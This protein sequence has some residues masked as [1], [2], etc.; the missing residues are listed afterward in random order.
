MS[1]SNGHTLQTFPGILYSSAFCN[2]LRDSNMRIGRICVYTCG[3]IIKYF[4]V[5]TQ[6][7]ILMRTW[8]VEQNFGLTLGLYFRIR[9]SPWPYI[10]IMY[11]LITLNFVTVRVSFGVNHSCINTLCWLFLLQVNGDNGFTATVSITWTNKRPKCILLWKYTKQQC[12]C[13]IHAEAIFTVSVWWSICTPILKF[14]ASNI[15]EIWREFQNWKSR[16]LPNFAFF[17]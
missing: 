4:R 14:P 6:N 7:C 16:S 10:K 17:R 13:L 9:T 8:L 15:L 5:L 12:F 1:C 11:A 2:S 3:R